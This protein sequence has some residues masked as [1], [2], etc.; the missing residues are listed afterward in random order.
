[1][2]PHAAAAVEPVAAIALGVVVE[3]DAPGALRVEGELFARFVPYLCA[4]LFVLS[5]DDFC[6]GGLVAPD[7]GPGGYSGDGGEG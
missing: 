1:L 4:V 2:L 3:F 5:V 6:G 7:E